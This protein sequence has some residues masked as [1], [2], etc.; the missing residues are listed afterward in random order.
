[1]T[2]QDFSVDLKPL[3]NLNANEI[4]MYGSIKRKNS[5]D[6]NSRIIWEGKL[7]IVLNKHRCSKVS[8]STASNRNLILSASERGLG[9]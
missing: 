7:T 5:M 1:M 4:F 2:F 8:T 6:M 9:R 3:R